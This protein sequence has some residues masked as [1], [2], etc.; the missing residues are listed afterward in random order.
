MQLKPCSRLVKHRL[1]QPR[2]LVFWN[3]ESNPFDHVEIS[4]EVGTQSARVSNIQGRGRR[5]EGR[6]LVQGPEAADA[7]QDHD[8]DLVRRMGI[9]HYLFETEGLVDELF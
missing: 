9:I 1:Y 2:K 7:N 6:L 8:A 4:E 5:R 3:D